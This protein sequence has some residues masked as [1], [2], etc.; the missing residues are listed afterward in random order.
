MNLEEIKKELDRRTADI[1]Q[2]LQTSHE[3][4]SDLI[5]EAE[6]NELKALLS[7][8]VKRLDAI[9]DRLTDKDVEEKVEY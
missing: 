5:K 9:E 1:S 8:V 6:Q 7:N 4:L 3:Y 2:T